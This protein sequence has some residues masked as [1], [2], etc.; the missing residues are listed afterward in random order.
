ML[1][2]KLS[3]S[4]GY[5][6]AELGLNKTLPLS[7]KFNLNLKGDTGM[8]I[9]PDGETYAYLAGWNDM[10][11]V[12][13]TDPINWPSTG[14][15]EFI[16]SPELKEITPVEEPGFVS[17]IPNLDRAFCILIIVVF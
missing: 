2:G 10:H 3:E 12:D 8:L 14:E 13:V 17:L 4:D 1:K 16:T 6:E 15:K 5:K 9:T 11:I 7:N